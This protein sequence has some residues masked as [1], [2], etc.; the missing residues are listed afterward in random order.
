MLEWF[1]ADHILAVLGIVGGALV[2]LQK[3]AALTPTKADDAIVDRLVSI[4]QSIEAAVLGK[5]KA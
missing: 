5:P 4:E 1:T 2:V 3:V